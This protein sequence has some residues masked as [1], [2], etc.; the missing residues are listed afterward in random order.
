MLPA[1]MGAMGALG[2]GGGG[3]MPGFSDASSA[4]S[5]ASVNYSGMS[6]GSGGKKQTE[7]PAFLLAAMNGGQTTGGAMPS[8]VMKWAIPAALVLGVVVIF[9]VKGR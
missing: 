3:G 9:A 5:S 6:V 2:G 1:I 4:T 7:L 8:S